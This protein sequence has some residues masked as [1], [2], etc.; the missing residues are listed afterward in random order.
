MTIRIQKV[1]RLKKVNREALALY[2]KLKEI[3]IAGRHE[4]KEQFGGQSRQFLKGSMQ[5]C[6]LVGLHNFWQED[7]MMVESPD[8]PD[9]VKHNPWRHAGWMRAWQARCELERA[10]ARQ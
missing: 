8:P 9:Y 5:L 7:I 1:K 2:V 10:A 6:K 4:I 3:K